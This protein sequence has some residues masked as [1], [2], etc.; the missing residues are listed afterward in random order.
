MFSFILVE[1]EYY[2]DKVQNNI[3][4]AT[5]VGHGSRSKFLHLNNFSYN[6]KCCF[7]ADS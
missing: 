3:Q 7:G 1:V 5:Q 6:S 2:D 4:R